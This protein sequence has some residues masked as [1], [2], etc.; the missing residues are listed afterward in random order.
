MFSLVECS[1]AACFAGWKAGGRLESLT[2][3]L[4]VSRGVGLSMPQPG[5]RPALLRL[6]LAGELPEVL[7]DS[8]REAIRRALR[9]RAAN[10]TAS[11]LACLLAHLDLEGLKLR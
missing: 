2:P 4:R 3:H 8:I 5:F 9:A 10:L 11:L 7:R 6:G 1:W